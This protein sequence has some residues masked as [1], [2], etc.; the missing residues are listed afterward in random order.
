MAR[1]D[2]QPAMPAPFSGTRSWA[3]LAGAALLLALAVRLG[4]CSGDAEDPVSPPDPLQLLARKPD[5]LIEQPGAIEPRG[6]VPGTVNFGPY[7]GNGWSGDELRLPDGTVYRETNQALAS[8]LLTAT[9]PAKRE[10]VLHLWCARPAGAEPAP[11]V[12]RMNGS[13]VTEKLQPGREPR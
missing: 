13:T 10:L 1:A 4:S 8:V 5:S 6:D 7:E 3:A 12:V 11:V 2:L 9:R